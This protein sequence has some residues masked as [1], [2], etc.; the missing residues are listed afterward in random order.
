VDIP[1]LTTFFMWCTIINVG[2]LATWIS[3][4][5]NA[6]DFVFRLQTK[7]FPMS[8]DVFNIVVYA[9]FSAYRIAFVVFVL[10]PY[11]ALLIVR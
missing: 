3:V 11:L 4:F 8:Q 7:Y 6:P 9:G 2:I 1:T 5:A 10:V